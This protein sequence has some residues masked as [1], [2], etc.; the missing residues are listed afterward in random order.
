MVTRQVEIAAFAK[1]PRVTYVVIDD[2]HDLLMTGHSDIPQGH[3]PI[4]VR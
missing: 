3:W 4:G 2:L 1:E